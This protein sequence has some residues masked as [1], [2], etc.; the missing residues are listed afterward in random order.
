MLEWFI[1]KDADIIMGW[2]SEFRTK[3]PFQKT[4]RA[5]IGD[6][7]TDAPPYVNQL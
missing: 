1:P 7:T 3:I 6:L 4:Q 2:E 5:E